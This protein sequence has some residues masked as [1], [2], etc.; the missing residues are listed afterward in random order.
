MAVTSIGGKILDRLQEH[1]ESRN[2]HLGMREANREILS[3]SLL[4]ARL[5]NAAYA[6]THDELVEKLN[7]KSFKDVPGGFKVL[8]FQNQRYPACKD[9]KIHPQ[10]FLAEAAL[11]RSAAEDASKDDSKEG[12]K[13]LILVFR[14]TQSTND[15][16]RNACISSEEQHGGCFH[17]GFLQGV[18][19]DSELHDQLRQ[20]IRQGCD[21]LYV[22]GHSLGGA[23][24]MTLVSANLLPAEYTGPVTVVGLGAP[25]V[26]VSGS[27]LVGN[28]ERKTPARFIV[29][30]NDRDVV[31]RLLGSR[32]PA[33]AAAMH[34]ATIS[35]P[36]TRALIN[37]YVALT[38][39]MEQYSHP[40]GTEILLL[41]DG[42]SKSVPSSEHASVLH[43]REAL[44]PRMLDDHLTASYIRELEI[45]ATLAEV[46]EEHN[47]EFV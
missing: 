38:E 16:I 34:A 17:R 26:R 47:L 20:A 9:S 1:Y 3:V 46:L 10:W 33:S 13:A 19:D 15:F 22:F 31:P 41:K 7:S 27:L 40:S 32:L 45:A 14:G 8:H 35:S 28:D 24:A 5:A 25:P 23:L 21:H 42:T 30:V 2:R 37:D 29:V 12:S 43:W 18:R 36:T 6:K 4:A 44:S 39:T 11:P